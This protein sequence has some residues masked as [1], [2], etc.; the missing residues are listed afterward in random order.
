MAVGGFS[1]AHVHVRVFAIA[2]AD[3][4]VWLSATLPHFRENP[5]KDAV[6]QYWSHRGAKAQFHNKLA[7][8]TFL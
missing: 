8:Y 2:A 1:L 4:S 3:F 7:S 6:V 5:G